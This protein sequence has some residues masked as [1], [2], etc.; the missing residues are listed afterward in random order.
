MAQFDLYRNP[1]P[2]TSDEFPYLVDIQSE[3]LQQLAI[4]VVIPLASNAKAMNHLNP[5]FRV[6]GKEM[7][8]MTQEMAGIERAHLGEKVISMKDYRSDIIAS[9]DFLISGF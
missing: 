5:V 4:C 8:L 6:E 9:V 7:V 3:L 2:L 1:N